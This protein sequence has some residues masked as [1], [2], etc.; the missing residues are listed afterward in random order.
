M[1]PSNDRTCFLAGV[2]GNLNDGAA[3][4]QGGLAAAARVYTSGGHWFLNAS[5][6]WAVNGIATG[7]PVNAH[8]VCIGTTANLTGGFIGGPGNPVNQKAL[9]APAT[10]NR[11]CFLA[12]VRGYRGS[13]QSS[14]ASVRT[15]VENGNWY[16]EA[17]NIGTAVDSSLFAALCVDVPPGSWVGTGAWGAANP[18]SGT[19][20]VAFE[21][22][23][24]A[25]GLT[26]IQGPLTFND[27]ADGALLNWPASSPGTWTMSLKD[28]KTGF[29]TCVE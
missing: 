27:W 26:G 7:N 11:Q 18:G 28:G 9:I 2:A 17:K 16:L 8:A 6:G 5:G 25:C 21:S 29:V 1:G 10:A 13:W 19:V 20:N 12:D 15:Y 14:A 24:M 22:N 23:V 3:S 4:A